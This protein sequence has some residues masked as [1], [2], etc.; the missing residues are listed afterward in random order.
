VA[1]CAAR[2]GALLAHAT[3]DL[4]ISSKQKCGGASFNCSGAWSLPLPSCGCIR[5]KMGQLGRLCEMVERDL[6]QR[7]N[8]TGQAVSCCIAR[9]ISHVLGVVF[10]YRNFTGQSNP[11]VV[12]C[13]PIGGASTALLRTGVESSVINAFQEAG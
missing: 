13:L 5:I 1:L 4:A 9:R 10:P 7:A 3:V 2:R 12:S 11:G 6:Y 8:T